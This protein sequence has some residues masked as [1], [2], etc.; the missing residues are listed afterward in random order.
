M[1]KNLYNKPSSEANES[2]QLVEE[3]KADIDAAMK[4]FIDFV[5]NAAQEDDDNEVEATA[6]ENVVDALGLDANENQGHEKSSDITEDVEIVSGT[7][8]S[9]NLA[10][11]DSKGS[12]ELLFETLHTTASEAMDISDLM[13][14]EE[15][16]AKEE[17]K[18][19]FTCEPNDNELA[20][21]TAKTEMKE[22]KIEVLDTASAL[23]NENED[24]KAEE[25]INEIGIPES[26]KEGRTTKENQ[27]EIPLTASA[28][29]H[30]VRVLM[31]V[32][33]QMMQNQE[34][35]DE[36]AEEPAKKSSFSPSK[37][38][39]LLFVLLCIRNFAWPSTKTTKQDIVESF[40]NIEDHPEEHSP[41][42]AME[43]QEEVVSMINCSISKEDIDS[44]SAESDVA[45]EEINLVVTPAPS[46]IMEEIVENANALFG[47]YAP[48]E[49]CN[50]CQD[51]LTWT[52]DSWQWLCLLGAV[53]MLRLLVGSSSNASQNKKKAP[54]IK[55]EALSALDLSRYESL[56]VVE[57]R[58][59]LR[60]KGCKTVGKK[61][62]LVKRLAAV[63]QAELETLTVKQLYPILKSK[64]YTQNGRKADI[65][66]TLVEEGL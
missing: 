50:V 11:S 46:S 4:D 41:I 40:T 60:S 14:G 63:Y 53:T 54:Y 3:E 29:S 13:V 10:P 59:L 5:V 17:T 27:K 23:L 35:V 44:L 38:F 34:P 2:P 28:S 37:V 49:S 18:V 22:I 24:P 47:D 64:G 9:D 21:P 32:G 51:V 33:N 56:K 1:F 25:A 66:Q 6:A 15:T 20:T 16:E 39:A 65:I 7:D 42:I 45:D 43:K 19:D 61:H 57:L 55:K 8:D 52:K 31:A 26:S 36:I 62:V 58:E 12:N 48:Q 30:D